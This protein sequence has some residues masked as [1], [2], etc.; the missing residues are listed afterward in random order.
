MMDDETKK[1]L[2]LA[3]KAGGV[4][5]DNSQNKNGWEWNWPIGWD[6]LEVDGDA[7]KL[8]VK[9]KLDLTHCHPPSIMASNGFISDF[10]GLGDDPYAATRRAITLVAAK[11]G[12]SMP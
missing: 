11:I 2:E 5:V 3:A 9:L 10:W 7:F 12:E 6:P 8:A 4:W 1:M